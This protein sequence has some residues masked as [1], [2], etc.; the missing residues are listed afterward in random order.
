M[1]AFFCLGKTEMVLKSIAILIDVV[2]QLTLII[3]FVIRPTH[4]EYF[5]SISHLKSQF[6]LE[7]KLTKEMRTIISEK[8]KRLEKLKNFYKKVSHIG[9]VEPQN[10]DNIIGHPLTAYAVIKRLLFEWKEVSNLMQVNSGTG[11]T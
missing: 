2:L 10:Y 6:H 9:K 1:F 7:S 4:S 5:T 3:L 11:N 8:Q